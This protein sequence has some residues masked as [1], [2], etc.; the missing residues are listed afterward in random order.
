L[1]DAQH[2]GEQHDRIQLQYF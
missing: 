2:E 1:A